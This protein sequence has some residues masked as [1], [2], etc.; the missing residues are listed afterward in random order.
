[1]NTS[2]LAVALLAAGLL[3]AASGL[4]VSVLAARRRFAAGIG[5][6]ERADVG[7]VVMIVGLAVAIIG[8]GDFVFLLLTA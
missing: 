3:A 1:M 8:G 2:Q 6:R 7:F 5:P 4:L